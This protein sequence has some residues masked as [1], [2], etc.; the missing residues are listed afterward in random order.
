MKKLAVRLRWSPEDEIDVAQIAEIDHRIFFEFDAGFLNRRL[1]VSPFKLPLRA[2]LIEHSDRATIGPLPGL[3][4]DSLPD[5]WGRLLMD[6]MF[7]K[8]G[9]DPA[10]VSPLDRLSYIGSRGMGALTF[11]PPED[12]QDRDERLL[13]LP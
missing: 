13:D 1:N 5:G 4:D 9:F 2:G 11:H 8:R 3:I 7:R 10:A 6:R 12:L